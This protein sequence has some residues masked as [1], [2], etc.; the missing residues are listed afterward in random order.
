MSTIIY[1]DEAAGAIFVQDAIG[2]QFL[3]SLQAFIVNPSDVVLSV[4]DVSKGIEIFSGIGFE[5]F[6]DASNVSYG[7]DVAEVTNAL[8]AMFQGT[9][10]TGDIPVITSSLS[11]NAVE[12]VNINYE[13]T[14]TNGV[15][16]EWSNLPEGLTVASGN[17]RLLLGN[18]ATSGTYT[19]T[20][21]AINYF[22]SD[23]ETL[24]ITV[25]NPPFANTKSIRFA[26]N[27]YL[28]G[29]APL[30]E[31][32]LGRSGNGSGAGDAWTVAMYFKA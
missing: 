17:G 20:V 15:S 26:N 29:N 3:N 2:V 1:K 13:L 27:D 25:S 28:S 10:S 18:I 32:T 23:T 12:G 7:A 16:Y 4:L 21:K 30:I 9:G 14:V 6:V 24:T 31:P 11:I 8:N 5:D 19:P 22:G